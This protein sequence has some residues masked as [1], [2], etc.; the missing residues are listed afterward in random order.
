MIDSII[1]SN[2]IGYGRDFNPRYIG[3]GSMEL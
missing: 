2:T 3:I 1:P